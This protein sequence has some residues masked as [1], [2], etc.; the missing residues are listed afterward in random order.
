MI[1]LTTAGCGERAPS[2]VAIF[3]AG[4]TGGAVASRIES[5]GRACRETL[6]LDWAQPARQIDQLRAIEERILAGGGDPGPVTVLWSAGRAGF[7]ATLGEVG[8]ELAA[9]RRVLD[10][11]GRIAARS[12]AAP[13]TFVLLGSAGGLF[14]GQSRVDRS[15]VAAPRRPY[16]TLKLEQESLLLASPTPMVKKIYRLTS[17]YGFIRPGQRQGLIPS[18]IANGL[19]RRVCHI[20]GQMSTLRDFVWVDDVARFLAAAM[21]DRDERSRD[22]V[23]TLA[24]AKPSSI[25]EIQRIVE[26]TLRRRLFVSYSNSASNS[27]DITFSP[28][29]LPPGWSPSDVRSSVRRIYEDAVSRG[30]CPA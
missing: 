23:S 14:E 6:P 22:S 25:L 16:G 2:I 19:H 18:L 20:T 17:V 7:G 26:S 24:S 13:L 29:L 21:L 12:P 4:L 3:G 27:E 11:A 5:V 28:D 10:L 15:S 8:D 9:Y 30:A 1:L